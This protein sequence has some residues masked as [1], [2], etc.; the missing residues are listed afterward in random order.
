MFSN[1]LCL[2]TAHSDTYKVLFDVSFTTWKWV[3]TSIFGFLPLFS[4][5]S[6]FAY[7]LLVLPFW[8]LARTGYMDMTYAAKAKAWARER[9][10]MIP[11]KRSR[12]TTANSSDP[13]VLETPPP[14]YEKGDGGSSRRS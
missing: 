13:N 12:E 5:L 7:F 10:A 4:A 8:H 11:L 3:I 2:P 14:A 9:L 6:F 1:F